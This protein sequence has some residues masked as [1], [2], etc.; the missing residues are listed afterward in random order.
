MGTR[1]EKGVAGVFG[2]AMP[3]AVVLTLA[4]PSQ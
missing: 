2:F 3:F 1:D 4:T